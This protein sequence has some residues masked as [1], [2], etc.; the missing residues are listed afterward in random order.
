MEGVATERTREQY[1]KAARLLA[2]GLAHGIVADTIG[3][4]EETIRLLAESPAMMA[5]VEDIK[6]GN[7]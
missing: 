4:T 5:R 2:E 6:D 7:K 3:W 1:Q